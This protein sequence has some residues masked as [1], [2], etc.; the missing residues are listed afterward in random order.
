MSRASQSTPRPKLKT[1]APRAAAALRQPFEL[2]RVAVERRRPARFETEK[3]FRLRVGDR[4][5]RAEVLDV[6]GR[7]RR[8]QRHV[9]PHHARKRRD[10]A[11]MIHA[12]LEHAEADACG[13]ARER[14]RHAPV[15]VIGGGGG[16]GRADAGEHRAQHLLHG[17][18]ADRAGHRNNPRPRARARSDAQPFHGLERV[19]DR[20]RRAETGEPPG[21]FA[22]HDGRGSP[23]IE[24]AS[25]VIM[26]VVRVAL[27][28]EEKIAGLKRATVDR[29]AADN[30]AQRRARRGA[31]CGR[32]FGFSPQRRHA[33]SASAAR[34]SSASENG[35]VVSPTIWPN[36]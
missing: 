10:F 1:R 21:P 30:L 3:D 24:G 25:D 26:A 16:V 18:L 31:E 27:D 11:R 6:D 19:V 8:H 20:E 29:D 23:G 2:W 5:D 22:R 4:L 13:H 7:D 9:R 36:S 14:Q 35:S 28:G 34:A 12:D 32:Q 17:R 33:A 15:I